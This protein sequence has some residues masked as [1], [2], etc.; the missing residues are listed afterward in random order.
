MVG[1]VR[2][3]LCL[4]VVVCILAVV[5]VGQGFGKKAEKVFPRKEELVSIG[6]D[7]CQ[8]AV[9][10][11]VDMVDAERELVLKNHK[12]EEIKVLNIIENSCDPK[13][14]NGTW[15]KRMDIVQ[16]ATAS[17]KYLELS[18]PGGIGKCKEE[19]ATIA[20]SCENLFKNDFDSDDF[21][22][23]LYKKKIPVA[24]VKDKVCKQWTDRCKPKRKFLL[25]SYIRL[26][27]QLEVLSDKEIQMEELMAQME[28]AGMGGSV[29][30]RDS[31]M[32]GMGDMDDDAYGDPYGGMGGMGGMGGDPYEGMDM[33][34]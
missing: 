25:K 23:L 7:V 13:H 12:L 17:G 21:S 2:V 27:E 9:E 14:A 4:Y 3:I 34:F 29:M 16:S 32:G 30:D 20:A 33:E 22:A 15:I 24:D 5:V 6:C 8:N 26:D 28:A 11:I 1:A 31:M 18:E 10:E 19:C